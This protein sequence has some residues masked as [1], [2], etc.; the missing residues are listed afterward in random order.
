MLL[1][2]LPSMFKSGYFA[3]VPRT[4]STR[5]IPPHHNYL[6]LLNSRMAFFSSKCHYHRTI[7]CLRPL[8]S[9][10]VWR[11]SCTS[12]WL[13]CR[14]EFASASSSATRRAFSRNSFFKSRRDF[15]SSWLMP[16]FTRSAQYFIF[17]LQYIVRSLHFHLLRAG[18]FVYFFPVAGSRHI[19]PGTIDFGPI[20]Q[21]WRLSESSAISHLF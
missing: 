9:A 15:S 12:R 11:V 13:F 1:C 8:W 18:F 2:F 14:F 10:E 6:P 4:S 20:V 3:V 7:S 17:V 21:T 19:A 5:W 16:R